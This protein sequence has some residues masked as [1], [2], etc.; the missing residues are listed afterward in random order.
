MP[1]KWYH[2][3]MLFVLVWVVGCTDT[4]TANMPE[5]A[6]LAANT[7]NQTNTAQTTITNGALIMPPQAT[8]QVAEC[9]QT[10]TPSLLPH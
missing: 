9:G 7:Q 5:S 4:S 10:I 1:G 8:L 6:G 2:W 3:I